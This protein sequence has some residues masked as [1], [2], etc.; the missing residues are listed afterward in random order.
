MTI[1][2]LDLTFEADFAT[3]PYTDNRA[4]E[5]VVL[6]PGGVGIEVTEENK[7]EYL[8]LLAKHRLVGDS[9]ARCRR[10]GNGLGVFFGD[11][12]SEIML[13]TR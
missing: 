12:T 7:A 2:D 5:P 8:E 1:A 3:E 6:K 10:S 13:E 11:A 9:K 4:P